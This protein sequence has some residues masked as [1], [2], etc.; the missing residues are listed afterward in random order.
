MTKLKQVEQN[1]CQWSH[2]T[3]RQKQ[4]LEIKFSETA[5]HEIEI[6]KL[7]FVPKYI[8]FPKSGVRIKTHLCKIV[9][10]ISTSF[11]YLYWNL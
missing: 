8:I 4:I 1:V 2:Y 7:G 9:I 3:V 5:F 10:K 11:A 6:W